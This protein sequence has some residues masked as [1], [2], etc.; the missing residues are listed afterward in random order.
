[1]LQAVASAQIRS[2]RPYLFDCPVLQRRNDRATLGLLH[3]QV[4][5]DQ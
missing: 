1:M 4:S 3:V 2:G 5:F